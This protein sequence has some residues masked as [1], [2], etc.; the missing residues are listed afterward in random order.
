[1]DSKPKTSD[2]EYIMFALKIMGDFG[3]SIAVPAVLA[4]ILGQWLD[5]RYGHVYLFT[6]ICF[7]LAAILTALSIRK[8]AMRYGEEFK[9]MD[10]PKQ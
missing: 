10:R 6:A 7:V 1:M 9:K 8:K 5:N 4:A 3:V 2:R